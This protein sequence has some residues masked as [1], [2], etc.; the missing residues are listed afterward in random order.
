MPS[1]QPRHGAHGLFDGCVG[2][3]AVLIVEVDG[4]NAQPPQAAF[5]RTAH[6]G[7]IAVYTALGGVGRIAHDAELG[8]QEYLVA[9]AL[10]RPAHQH[11]VGVRTVDVGGVEQ[12]DAQLQGAVDGGQ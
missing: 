9:P 10:D 8:G 1:Y 12:V 11:L 7:R 2:I 4:L 3:Y 6:I 5:D